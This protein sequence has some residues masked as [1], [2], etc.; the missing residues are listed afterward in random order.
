MDLEL[1]PD[2]TINKLAI[3]IEAAPL[4]VI[5]NFVANAE[6]LV[7]IASGKRYLEPF[8]FYPGLRAKAPLSYQRL[9]IEKLKPTLVECFGV[10]P[11]RVQFTMAHFSL[12]TKSAGEL[13]PLQTVPH[14]DSSEPGLATVHY[15]FKGDFGG[16]AFYRHRATGFEVI[17]EDRRV[18]FLS[19]L[20]Q[21]LAGPSAPPN[22]YINGD[23]PLFEQISSQ[24]GVFNRMLIYRRNSLHSGAISKSFVPS[25]DPSRG[26]LS[27]N[28]FLS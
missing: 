27:V 24:K 11:L 12:V 22:E 7:D 21:Q 2:F 8:R 18:G 26:R 10:D 19:L 4:I 14:I 1:H 23:T 5:D 15:L 20:H 13:D 25:S 16:T 28:C 9:I 3:G 6:S 17:T